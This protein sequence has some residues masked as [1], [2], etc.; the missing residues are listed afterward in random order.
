MGPA[1][2][3]DDV[4]RKMII[5]GM[6][7]ARLNFSHGSHDYHLAGDNDLNSRNLCGQIPGTG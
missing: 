3:N 6:T 5:A 7:V 4:L 2:D 1:T